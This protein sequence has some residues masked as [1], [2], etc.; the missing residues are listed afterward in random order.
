MRTS[1]KI[2]VVAETLFSWI[3]LPFVIAF[4]VSA[5]APELGDLVSPAIKASVAIAFALVAALFYISAGH[6]EKHG[7]LLA[8]LHLAPFIILV[9]AFALLATAA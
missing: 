7:K 8:P 5:Y 3:T 4:A 1:H 6:L 9:L 2:I